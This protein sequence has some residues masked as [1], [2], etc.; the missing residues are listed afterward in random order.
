M[1]GRRFLVLLISTGLA[2]YIGAG[3]ARAEHTHCRAGY[4]LQVGCYARLLASGWSDAQVAASLISSAEF[5]PGGD[6]PPNDTVLMTNEV[7]VL[8]QR[9]ASASSRNDAII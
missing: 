6:P 9:A 7:Q 8:L 5:A 3:R 2:S 1:E 4:P